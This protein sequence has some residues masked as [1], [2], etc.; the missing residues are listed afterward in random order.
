VL[1]HVPNTPIVQVDEFHIDV[2]PSLDIG[3]LNKLEIG[4]ASQQGTA[5]KNGTELVSFQP[6]VQCEITM[7]PESLWLALSMLQYFWF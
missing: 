2:G 7:Q 3:D 1:Q 4:F 5:G 6:Y